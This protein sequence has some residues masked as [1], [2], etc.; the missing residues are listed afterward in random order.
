MT[1]HDEDE[2]ELCSREDRRSWCDRGASL[3]EYAMLIA[4]ITIVCLGALQMFGE[5]NE[6]LIEGSANRIGEASGY[7]PGD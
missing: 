3:V 4:L 1:C 6:G 5:E 7:D 2:D